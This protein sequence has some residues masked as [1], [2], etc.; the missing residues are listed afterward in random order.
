MYNVREN[1]K[2]KEIERVCKP[3]VANLIIL[4]AM[5]GVSVSPNQWNP[6]CCID[7]LWEKNWFRKYSRR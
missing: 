2:R 4:A 3:S 1:R 7:T 6:D 5:D